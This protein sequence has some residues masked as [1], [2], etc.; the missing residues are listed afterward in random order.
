MGGY[1]RIETQDIDRLLTQLKNSQ[2]D[3]RSALTALKDVGP[4]STGSEALDNSCDEFH[5]SWDNAIKKIAD[6]AEQIEEKLRATKKN[7]EATEEAIRNA[8]KQGEKPSAEPRPTPSKPPAESAPSTPSPSPQ[9]SPSG[10][11]K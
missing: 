7:Y 3:M 11:N 1:F 5:D 9:P 4:K 8:L 2:S 6:G 10:E